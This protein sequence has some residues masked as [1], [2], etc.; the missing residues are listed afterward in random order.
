MC[1]RECVLVTRVCV[2]RVRAYLLGK[3]RS[4]VNADGAAKRLSKNNHTALTKFP[5]VQ[6]IQRSLC[7]FFISSNYN[8][9]SCEK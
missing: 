1:A 6:I 8:L 9:F 3:V 2:P 4:K 5:G 7:A